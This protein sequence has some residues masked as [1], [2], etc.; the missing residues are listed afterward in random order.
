MNNAKVWSKM[1]ELQRINMVLCAAYFKHPRLICSPF[2]INAHPGKGLYIQTGYSVEHQFEKI[3][4]E[5]RHLSTDWKKGGCRP[6]MGKLKILLFL[7]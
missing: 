2:A 1:W 7:F 4:M 6:Q 3:S 5:D